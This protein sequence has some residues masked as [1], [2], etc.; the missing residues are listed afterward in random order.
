MR[1]QF[2]GNGD[3]E[4]GTWILCFAAAAGVIA[5]TSSVSAIIEVIVAGLILAGLAKLKLDHDK[6]S[7]R[8]PVRVK[9][10]PP[11]KRR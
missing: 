7:E 3:A 2:M 10:D 9:V 5:V 6:A 11:S 1:F 8:V 4:R